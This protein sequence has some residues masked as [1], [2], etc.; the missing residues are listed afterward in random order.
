MAP[1][2]FGDKINISAMIGTWFGTLF[3]LGGLIAVIAQLRSLLKDF[4]TSRD[5]MV[6]AAAGDW[7]ICLP[8]LQHSDVGIIEGKAPSLSAW[9][10][11]YYSEGKSITICPYERRLV[12]GQ[13][14]WSRLFCRLQIHPEE[15]MNLGH[16]SSLDEQTPIPPQLPETADILVDGSKISYGLPGDEF[17]ALLILSGFSPSAYNPKETTR[18]T[19][20]LGHMYLAAHSDPFSQV[21]QLDSASWNY[22]STFHG[23]RWEGRYADRLNIRHCLDLALGILRFYCVG[24]PATLL[25]ASRTEKTSHLSAPIR[26]PW[27]R[28][29]P[30]Q[31]LKIRRSLTE[32]TGGFM[33]QNPIYDIA[34]I[35]FP[36]FSQIFVGDHIALGGKAFCFRL[37]PPELDTVFEIAFGL[38][39]LK[40]WGVLPVI[41]RSIVDAFCPLLQELLA[42]NSQNISR[43]LT[44]IQTFRGLPVT[45]QYNVPH[46]T[47]EAMDAA[48][49]SLSDVETRNFSGLTARCSLYYDA[50]IYVFENNNL[51][52]EDVEIGLAACCAAEYAISKATPLV[53]FEETVRKELLLEYEQSVRAS[54]RECLKGSSM[55]EV[56]PW[57]CK[58]LATYLHAW[59]QEAKDIKK[60][61]KHNFRRRVFLG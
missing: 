26:P 32:L 55:N 6:K 17:A 39:A 11:H 42:K 1:L 60:G 8:K 61:F 18:T 20:H 52:L 33:E 47:R 15:L 25:F 27:P 36:N 48:L 16:R 4:S 50:M 24:K 13:S 56:P 31:I 58:I 9:I 57:A 19:S 5:E 53:Q 28:P 45:V 29:S 54:L 3:T 43:P 22:F 37:D 12:S 46:R 49:N 7:A 59:L 34:S 44:L 30:R 38:K 10:Q 41:P 40:P 23:V 14:S 35:A 21:A 2:A 51:S